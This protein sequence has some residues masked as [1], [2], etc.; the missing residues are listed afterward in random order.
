MR[1]ALGQRKDGPQYIVTQGDGIAFNSEFVDS[2][3]VRFGELA[4]EILLGHLRMSSSQL[5]SMCLKVESLYVGPLLVPDRCT[6]PYFTHMRHVLQ[7][8]FIDCMIRGVDVAIEEEDVNSALWMIEAALRS[9]AGRE[10]VVRRALQV[11]EL[12]GRYSDV[13]E[14]YRMHRE[15]L[16]RQADRAPEPETER[17]YRQIEGRRLRYG[18]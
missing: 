5:I 9:E 14:V 13:E 4:R 18:A 17:V 15:H 6:I 12:A 2:D 1:H 3:V 16:R 11:Y 7:T 10:D 8:K